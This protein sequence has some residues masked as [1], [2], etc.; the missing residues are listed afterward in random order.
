[1]NKI[2]L[3]TIHDTLN[4]G[5]LLQ[6]VSLYKAV[7]SL[8]YDI[9]LIDY[10]NEAIAKRES[11]YQLK[12][13]R[14]IKDFYKA[15]FHHHFLEKKRI[16]FWKY[17]R[18]NM[19]VT[20]PFDKVSIEKTNELFD[21]FL[22]GSDIVWGMDIT[23]ADFN[24]ML[25]FARPEKRKIAFSSSMGERWPAYYDKKIGNLLKGFNAIS[26][27]EQLSAQWIFDLIGYEVKTTCDPT[28]L[29]DSEF[30][31]KFS[32]KTL[33][34][35]NK[36]IL[37]Y[38]RT[39]DKRTIKDALAYG[40]KKNLPVYYINYNHSEWGVKNI[41]PTT[42]EEWISLLANADT[43][44]TA[45]YHGLLFSLY[46]NRPFFWYNRANKARMNSLSREL[47]IENRE[48]TEHNILQDAPISFD[49][50]NDVIATKRKNSWNQLKAVLESR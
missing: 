17:I 3:I 4:F 24:Y 45:S 40:K 47:E 39:E 36:Y 38:F 28:M 22:V 8:N 26:V 29:W 13:C 32:D 1:M 6:T 19:V 44:F 41:R 42:V 20:D 37:V 5:S 49:K 48:G 16:Y 12:E 43:I 34:P 25:E 50:I 9:T 46:F 21:T 18:E 11:T 35:S 2:G 14:R 27:R 7:E 15:V 31:M 23:N 10:K 30:W 33:V